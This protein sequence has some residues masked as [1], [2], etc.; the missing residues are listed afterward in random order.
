MTK[1]CFAIIFFL[2][3]GKGYAQQQGYI[4]LIDADSDRAFRARIGDTIY[5]SSGI[6]H[7]AIPYLKDSSYNI[8]IGFL[9]KQLPEYIFSIRI[10][11]KDQGFQLK[12]LGEKGWAL[13]NWQTGELKMPLKDSINNQAILERRIKKDDA[14]SRLMA[15]VVN[16]TSVMYNA[17][18]EQKS[19]KDT[20]RNNTG[21]PGAKTDSSLVKG[22]KQPKAVVPQ[23]TT[24]V[25]SKKEK[26]AKGKVEY[27]YIHKLSE[28][29]LKR[30]MRIT[31]VAAV[32]QGSIDTITLFIPFE[33]EL[34]SIPASDSS[35]MIVPGK[36][37]K[38][39]LKGSRSSIDSVGAKKNLSNKESGKIPAISDC[40]N[41]ASDYDVDLLRVNILVENAEE[42]KVAAANKVFKIKCF[43]VKQL[44]KLSEL[45][46]NDKSR[47]SFFEAAYPFISDR[48]NISQLITELNDTAYINRFKEQMTVV[49]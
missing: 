20:L 27:P 2:I 17:V 5:N 48:G 39:I 36:N 44:K 18:M 28:R 46:T 10:N 12:N 22:E 21:N 29:S 11:K 42:A 33:N 3:T 23:A 13:Y 31:Y 34:S 47:Y 41:L 45:F 9:K 14:F 15:A 26:N 7:V 40:K 37:K 30:A 32:Q 38:R 8:G 35:K 16:D 6:G 25:H 1:I 4:V 24:I 49:R 43:S 19:S